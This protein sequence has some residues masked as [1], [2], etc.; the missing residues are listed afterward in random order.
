MALHENNSE[1]GDHL[2][3]AVRNCLQRAAVLRTSHDREAKLLR[4]GDVAV[5]HAYHIAEESPVLHHLQD[6]PV[7]PVPRHPATRDPLH[8][9]HSSHNNLAPGASEAGRA[10]QGKSKERHRHGHPR[11]HGNSI[12]HMRAARLH[13]PDHHD[14]SGV[15][16]RQTEAGLLQHDHEHA[17][18]GQFVGQL[19]HIRTDRSAV[20]ENSR[21][22]VLSD[23]H[24]DIAT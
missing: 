10:D 19:S 12:H 15:P 9:Q 22:T 5:F 3:H 1:E 8:P 23:L 7:F 24:Q 13:H 14:C 20:P 4:A 17:S 6:N 11:R 21:T 18:D 16:G 2:Y